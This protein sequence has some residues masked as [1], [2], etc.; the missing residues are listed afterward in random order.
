[1]CFL[2]LFV[3]CRLLV[4]GDYSSFLFWVTATS[5]RNRCEKR[6]PQFCWHFILKHEFWDC[7]GYDSMK[8]STLLSIED[9]DNYSFSTKILILLPV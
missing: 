1:M 8:I 5:F 3:G 9:P 7:I 4:F 6:K 2:S